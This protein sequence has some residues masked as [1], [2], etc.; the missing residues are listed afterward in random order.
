MLSDAVRT[1]TYRRAI[2]RYADECFRGRTV[3]DVG[4]GTGILSLFCVEAGA[5]A[6]YA[7]EASDMADQA[8][9]IVARNGAADRIHV[10]H[11][12]MER[13]ELPCKVDVIVSEW[14]G[15]GLLYESM[16][17][18]VLVARDKWLKEDGVMF[19]SIARMYLA[20]FTDEL[21]EDHSKLW[22]N[23]YGWDF[24]PILPYA[25]QCIY[26]DPHVEVLPAEALLCL[27]SKQFFSF[28]CKT[29][30][31]EQ[32]REV[33]TVFNFKS[34]Y[35]ADFHGIAVWFDVVFTGRNPD[36]EAGHYEIVLST[37]PESEPTHWAQVLLFLDK[38]IPV[39]QDQEIAGEL[40]LVTNAAC[41]RTVHYDITLADGTKKGFDL[42]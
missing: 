35:S 28:N 36:D 10:I 20:P 1:G 11:D 17:E 31:L 40:R 6:V 22:Q 33:K 13:A 39:E 15:Y 42:S 19:P 14:M 30:K 23:L 9:A 12:T 16:F 3:L 18:S 4:C 26:K 34:I 24:T 21:Y 32:L 8:R 27:R 38:A 5:S 37:S 29:V 2:L 25:Y 41:R 7:V